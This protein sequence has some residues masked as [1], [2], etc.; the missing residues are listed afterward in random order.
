M[1]CS[2]EMASTGSS[3]RSNSLRSNLTQWET[4]GRTGCDQAGPSSLPL[5]L[6]WANSVAWLDIEC[7]KE[8][9][10]HLA[11][12]INPGL[13]PSLIAGAVLVDEIPVAKLRHATPWHPRSSLETETNIALSRGR[14]SVC[15]LKVASPAY[16]S[17]SL[18]RNSCTDDIR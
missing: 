7:L 4:S 12:R 5:H 17:L 16:G 11:T 2:D 15:V 1:P 10:L 14:H 3:R 6:S 8:A 13:L 9:N 18:L